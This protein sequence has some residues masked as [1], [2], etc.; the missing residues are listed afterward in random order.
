[1]DSAKVEPTAAVL[2]KAEIEEFRQKG[3][4]V[5]RA[6]FTPA[7]V[8]QIVDWTDELAVRPEQPG[9][10]MVYGEISRNG[11][12]ERLIQRIENFCPYHAGFERIVCQGKL[13]T[14][15]DELF[16]EPSC[17]FKD[18]INFK[19]AGGAGFEPHQ[20]QQAGWSR[21]APLFITALVGVDRATIENGCLA[22]ADMPRLDKM[23]GPEWE[24][25]LDEKK[26]GHTLTPVLTE[27][28]DV[29]FF[30]SYVLHGSDPN[31][32]SAQRRLLYLTYNPLS[33]GDHRRRYFD[34]KRANFPPDI[35]RRPGDVYRF[36]V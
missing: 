20:D 12:G 1:M 2:T 33:R 27:P 15:I 6:F 7:E 34:E 25:L 35:E 16:D 17:L 9:R 3:W 10:E 5:R 26:G 18:K 14:A 36:R 30:D 19:M 21:Y 24:P 11:S 29:I 22:I 23:I 13:Q 8:R 31:E 28:G 32:S 4:V